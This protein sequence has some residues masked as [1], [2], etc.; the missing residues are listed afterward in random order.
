MKK[1]PG[2]R[3]FSVENPARVRDLQRQIGGRAPSFPPLRPADEHRT[4]RFATRN[5]ALFRFPR[6]LRYGRR[7]VRFQPETEGER[8]AFM[9][10]LDQDAVTLRV[11][12][13]VEESRGRGA[14]PRAVAPPIRKRSRGR[15]DSS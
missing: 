8:M 11:V 12:Q 15:P 9:F 10:K 7:A 1:R 2:E 14:A 5:A 13:R 4:R 3:A 6:P